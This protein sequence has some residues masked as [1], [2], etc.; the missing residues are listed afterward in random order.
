[1]VGVLRSTGEVELRPI[2]TDPDDI[3]DLLAGA[4]Q[5]GVEASLETVGAFPGDVSDAAVV[6]VHRIVREALTNVARHAGPVPAVVALRHG[7]DR[8]VVEV[9]NPPSTMTTAAAPPDAATAAGSTGVGVVGMRERA[10]SLGGSLEAGPTADGGYRVVAEVP[11]HAA[12]SPA[13]PRP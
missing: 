9:R 13:G 7:D 10:E 12:P 1:M 3:A 8:V 2:P 6:A 5:A 11:Y 4:A